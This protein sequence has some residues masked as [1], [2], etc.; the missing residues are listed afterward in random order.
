MKQ[1]WG[2]DVASLR[3]TAR[4]WPP[5]ATISG[6][7]RLSPKAT[8]EACKR[9]QKQ[10]AT[11]CR[12]IASMQRQTCKKETVPVRLEAQTRLLIRVEVFHW[13]PPL[14][15]YLLASSD[16]AVSG[17]VLSCRACAPLKQG[18]LSRMPNQCSCS[19]CCTFPMPCFARN[20][21]PGVHVMTE[22]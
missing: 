12:N 17:G 16:M 11:R 7:A 6:M 14:L 18:L 22:M 15:V 21:A 2:V 10:R 3:R 13:L 4:T 8:A 1:Y 9:L 19:C 5:M 20:A